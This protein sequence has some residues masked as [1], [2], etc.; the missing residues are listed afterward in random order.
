MSQREIGDY[1]SNL[2]FFMIVILGF[3]LKFLDGKLDNIGYDL[4]FFLSFTLL[5]SFYRFN[6]IQLDGGG[7]LYRTA[8][9][10]QFWP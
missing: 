5:K 7:R 9:V 2:P 3:L 10:Q 1:F 8:D 6:R 4:I